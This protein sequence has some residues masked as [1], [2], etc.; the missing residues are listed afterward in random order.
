[1]GFIP[2]NPCWGG[3][4]TPAPFSE[5]NNLFV[6]SLPNHCC[7]FI[8]LQNH[9]NFDGQRDGAH[10]YGRGDSPEESESGSIG[11]ELCSATPSVYG[12]GTDVRLSFD[13]SR[14]VSKAELSGWRP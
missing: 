8:M 13:K 5:C 9:H 14:R 10:V 1:M 3:G 12:E 2:F 11:S 4:S 6:V 7:A